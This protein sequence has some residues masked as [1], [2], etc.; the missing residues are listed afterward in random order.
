MNNCKC[1][2]CGK[3]YT[4]TEFVETENEKEVEWEIVIEKVMICSQCYFGS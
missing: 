4:S 2:N 3:L 1:V